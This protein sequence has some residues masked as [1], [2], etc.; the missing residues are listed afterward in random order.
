MRLLTIVPPAMSADATVTATES[1]YRRSP[2]ERT[3]GAGNSCS[4]TTLPG[5]AAKGDEPDGVAAVRCDDGADRVRAG[6]YA[7]DG[8][9]DGSAVHEGG[10]NNA[11]LV[12]RIR[13]EVDDDRFGST[14]LGGPVRKVAA[15]D[16]AQ[17]LGAHL[18]DRIL[19]FTIATTPSRPM[20]LSDVRT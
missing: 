20:A 14:A 6:R 3:L 4:A 1:G 12:R 15:H 5:T 13:R 2:I 19:R 11:S 17:L 18:T 10:R 7:N 16:L 9:A 8:L